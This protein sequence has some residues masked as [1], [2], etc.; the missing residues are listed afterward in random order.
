[1]ILAKVTGTLVA[2]QKNEK[3]QPHKILITHP[4]DLEYKLMGNKDVLAI[5]FAGS[6]IGDIVLMVQEGDAIQ[7]IVGRDDLPVHT[8]IIAVVDNIFIPDSENGKL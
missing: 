4:I 5:D 7:Q 2:T 1:M 6:G 8:G 3:L